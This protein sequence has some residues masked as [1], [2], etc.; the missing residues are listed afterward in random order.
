[1]LLDSRLAFVSALF[2]V[3]EEDQWTV[4]A[5]H[6]VTVFEQNRRTIKLLIWALR[7]EIS[8]TVHVRTAKSFVL[9]FFF[10]FLKKKTQVHDLFRLDSAASKLMGSY[11][12]LVAGMFVK[13]LVKS[14]IVKKVPKLVAKVGA[15]EVSLSDIWKMI[16]S[17]LQ[18]LVSKVSSAPF[19]LRVLCYYIKVNVGVCTFMFHSFMLFFEK[20]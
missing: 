5:E 11:V 4:L 14:A 3:V 2:D 12:Q 20:G 15:D 8:G 6:L 9:L 16:D 1:M 13:D 18:N 10:F 19:Q 7:K 17:M